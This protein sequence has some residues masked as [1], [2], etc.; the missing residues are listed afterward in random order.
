MTKI[1]EVMTDRPRAI[2]PQTSIREAA[3]LMEEEDVGSLPV[4]EEGARLVG[5]VTDRD[6]AIRAVARGLE[7]EG[8]AVMDIASREVYGLTPDDDLDEALEMMARAQVRRLPIVVRE[9]ELVGMVAQADVARMSKEKTTGEV[10]EA[11]SQPPHGPRVRAGASG[12]PDNPSREADRQRD[13]GSERADPAPDYPRA[14]TH[15]EPDA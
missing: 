12:E 15:Q 2:T 14:R 5:I 10:L 11:I 7:P 1:A 6:I 13:V 8:T 9:N 3:R 4:V